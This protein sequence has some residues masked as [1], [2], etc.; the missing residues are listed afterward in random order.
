M[1]RAELVRDARFPRSSAGRLRLL[2]SQPL[3]PCAMGP[4]RVSLT[5]DC[6]LRPVCPLTAEC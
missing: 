6:W 2:S 3:L 5:A 4:S 1:K